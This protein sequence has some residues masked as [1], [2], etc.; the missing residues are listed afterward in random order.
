M[1]NYIALELY[2]GQQDGVYSLKE[3]AEGSLD[4]RKEEYP[5][6]YWVL[7]EVLD[8]FHLLNQNLWA[9]HTE[10]LDRLNA[11]GKSYRAGTNEVDC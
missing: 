7:V 1:S 2:T 5:N 6:L 9:D 8:E 10:E 11:A 3:M 4:R